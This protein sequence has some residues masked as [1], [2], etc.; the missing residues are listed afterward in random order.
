MTSPSFK[1]PAV[2]NN[3]TTPTLVG[4][5]GASDTSIALVAGQGVYFPT[6]LRNTA[7]STGDARTLNSTGNLGSVAVGDYIYNLTDGSWAVVISISGAPNSVRTTP[8]EGGSLNVWTSGNTW[9]VGM[10]VATITQFSGSSIVKQ[11]RV[12]VTN[13]ATD[14]LTVVRGFDSDSTQTFLAGDSVQILVESSQMTN[15]H[16]A[17]RNVLGKIDALHRGTPHYSLTTGSANAYAATLSP[18]VTSWDD[19]IGKEIVLKLNFSN[20]GACTL[21]LNG[22]GA[23]SIKKLQGTTDPAS[24]DLQNGQVCTFCYDGTNVQLTSPIGNA[25]PTGVTWFPL[26]AKQASPSA[27]FP[28]TSVALYTLAPLTDPV[29]DANSSGTTTGTSLTF[30]HTRAANSNLYVTAVVQAGSNTVTGMTWN[31]IAG[32]L[33]GAKTYGGGFTTVVYGW[34][35][36]AGSGA[37]NVVINVSGSVKI[38]A[39]S[40]SYT[41]C[42][43]VRLYNDTSNGSAAA[44]TSTNCAL[45]TT[46]DRELVIT[47]AGGNNNQVYSAGAGTTLRKSIAQVGMF[48]S[49]AGVKTPAGAETLVAT[50][51]AVQDIAWINFG[52]IGQDAPSIYGLA[53]DKDSAQSAE[54]EYVL[55]SNYSVG[56]TIT[57][58]IHWI[59]IGSGDVVWQ[60]SAVAIGDNATIS[61]Y[62]TPVAITDT[63]TGA[64]K[65]NLS[66]TSS[67]ITIAGSPTAGQKFLLKVYRDAA[68]AADT[69]NAS[70]S[71]TAIEITYS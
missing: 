32:T 16:Y 6:I 53:F 58:K 20:T 18:V 37:A 36:P 43:A 9:I 42:N 14:T 3:A 12:L 23:K 50:T 66:P 5:I 19:V 64:N 25:P 56:V 60:V 21:N 31:G 29:Y 8:L 34:L 40:V 68:A 39:A 30:S 15:L 48:E 22:L 55:P 28:C 33:M 51:G 49:S 27:L 26:M 11:E 45:T 69:L 59:T 52:L 47:C 35:N 67:A 4:A 54:W 1:L 46:A 71:I 38:D 70:A 13:R 62:G 17:I 61:A 10:F 63:A 44:P 41:N 65:N 7:S 24:N 2:K 57:A